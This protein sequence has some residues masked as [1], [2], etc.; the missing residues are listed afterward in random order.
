MEC[1]KRSRVAFPGW[2]GDR[3]GQHTVGGLALVFVL[4]LGVLPCLPLAIRLLP[5]DALSQGLLKVASPPSSLCPR[6]CSWTS[7]RT[8]PLHCF[9]SSLLCS[10]VTLPGPF[11]LSE[12]KPPCLRVLDPFEPHCGLQTVYLHADSRECLVE[13]RSCLVLR[14]Q[15]DE[16]SSPGPYFW[17][18]E[19]FGLLPPICPGDS[20]WRRCLW[21]LTT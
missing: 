20:L 14:L 8:L 2:P 18:E 10:H 19:G 7:P 13:L 12:E 6:G 11:A 9:L 3:R 16:P 17:D 4:P 5:S 15:K 1:G 21:S